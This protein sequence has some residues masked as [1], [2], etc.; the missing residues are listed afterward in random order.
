M[1][2]P[3]KDEKE[4]EKEQTWEN[5]GRN[6]TLKAGT[7]YPVA[8]QA[9]RLP[10]V[11]HDMRPLAVFFARNVQGRDGSCLAGQAPCICQ[12]VLVRRKLRV[13]A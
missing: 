7:R 13:A 8:R 6:V 4:P 5:W 12:S 2:A 3:D 9:R 11:L 1:P 10:R